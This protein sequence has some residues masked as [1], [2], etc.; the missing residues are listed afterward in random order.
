MKTRHTAG[1]QKRLVV[2]LFEDSDRYS[3]QKNVKKHT[4]LTTIL[5]HPRVLLRS[6]EGPHQLH[7]CH[8]V[9]RGRGTVL[10]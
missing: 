6:G 9:Q 1:T 2:V 8:E 7:K 4:I 3:L 10:S 5:G